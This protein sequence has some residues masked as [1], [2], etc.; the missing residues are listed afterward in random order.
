MLFGHLCDLLSAN[1]NLFLTLTLIQVLRFLALVPCLKDA[2]LI[3]QQSSQSLDQPPSFLPS[4]VAQFLSAACQFD[5][6]LVE[7]F[8]NLLKDLLWDG[9]ESDV[10]GLTEDDIE[11]CFR[12]HGHHHGLGEL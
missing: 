10:V 1:I 2:I 11:E 12:V 5:E 7:Q 4:P 8:W 9:T 3:A 6:G